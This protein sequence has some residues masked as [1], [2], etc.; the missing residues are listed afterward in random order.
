MK[1]R[2]GYFWNLEVMKQ[3]T[4]MGLMPIIV[5]VRPDLVE[6]FLLETC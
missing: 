3:I 1:M 6:S 5:K 4:M 2:D